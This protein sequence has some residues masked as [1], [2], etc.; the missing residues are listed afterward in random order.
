[1]S[2]VRQSAMSKE[3]A[4]KETLLRLALG[5][6]GKPF[7]DLLARAPGRGVYVAAEELEKSLGSK[8]LDRVFRG[9]A[10]KLAPAEIEALVS[11]TAERLEARIVELVGLARRAGLLEIGTDAVLRSLE[12]DAAVVVMARDASERTVGKI[13]EALRSAKRIRASTKEELGRLLGRDEIGVVAVR[14]SK[15]ADRIS[16]ESLRLAGIETSSRPEAES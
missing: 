16:A 2:A 12:A 4:P 13:E 9:K 1:M 10:K 14:A 5:P 15:L 6:D 7:V 8:G 11:G 3:R